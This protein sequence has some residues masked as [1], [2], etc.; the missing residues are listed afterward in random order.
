MVSNLTLVDGRRVAVVGANYGGY[1]AMLLAGRLDMVPYFGPGDAGSHQDR[2]LCRGHIP[3]GGLE[4]PWWVA[5]TG[6]AWSSME[7]TAYPGLS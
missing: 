3:R 5:G 4:A 2:G 7:S 1:L 6:A